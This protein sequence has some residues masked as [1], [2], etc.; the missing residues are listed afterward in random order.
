MDRRNWKRK[1]KSDEWV[2]FSDKSFWE[3]VLLVAQAGPFQFPLKWIILEHDW[4]RNFSSINENMSRLITKNRSVGV[5][6][7]PTW[8]HKCRLQ[9]W[10]Q[11][12]LELSRTNT[13]LLQTPDPDSE[14]YEYNKVIIENIQGLWTPQSQFYDEPWVTIKMFSNVKSQMSKK[15][16]TARIHQ[17]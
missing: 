5:R 14:I 2:V 10:L 15:C 13:T 11:Q 3:N 6:N 16:A 17:H 9:P 8:I 4:R 7:K 12:N 1:Q